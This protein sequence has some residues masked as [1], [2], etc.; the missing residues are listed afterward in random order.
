[1]N[2]SVYQGDIGS[3]GQTVVFGDGRQLWEAADVNKVGVGP[4]LGVNA[5]AGVTSHQAVVGTSR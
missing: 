4:V 3:H 1:M 5:R 2:T